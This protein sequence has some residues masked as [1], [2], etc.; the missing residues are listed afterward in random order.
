[1]EI[2]RDEICSLYWANNVFIGSS[3]S[4][5]PSNNKTEKYEVK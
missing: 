2:E 3:L 1:M 5:F 4:F